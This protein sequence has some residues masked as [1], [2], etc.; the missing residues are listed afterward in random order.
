MPRGVRARATGKAPGRLVVG[1]TGHRRLGDEGPLALT[2]DA[3]LDEIE[4]RA[5]AEGRRPSGLTVLS[6]LAE[7]ADRLVARRILARPG[8]GLVA[9]LPLPERRYAEDF[10]TPGSAAE[11]RELLARAS[12][13]R[14][15]RGPRT[16][17]RAYAAA[18]R[19]VVDQCDVLLA[20]W[21]GR[22]EEGP[23]GTA[24]IVRYAKKK[25]RAVVWIN[26]ESGTSAALD[27]G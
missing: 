12:S 16:R 26:P 11:F 14:R 8:G 6:P 17:A 4:R 15:L 5:E 22:P 18:G 13:V 24:E 1:V 25:G 27:G 21:D 7:G 20:L 2:V 10:E 9:V 19:W 3:A 23:G